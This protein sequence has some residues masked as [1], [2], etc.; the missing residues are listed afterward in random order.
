MLM[1]SVQPPRRVGVPVLDLGRDENGLAVTD[2]AQHGDPIE[3]FAADIAGTRQPRGSCFL[4]QLGNPPMFE[5]ILHAPGPLRIGR[6][7][8]FAE[9]NF[10][11]ADLEREA[12]T[13]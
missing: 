13:T 9:R 8:T 6:A 3:Q 12:A 4:D 2:H 10:W 5:M 11:P 7:G 1:G